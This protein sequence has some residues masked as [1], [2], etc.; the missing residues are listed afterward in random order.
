MTNNQGNNL[1][2]ATV[3]LVVIKKEIIN[4]PDFF[5]AKAGDPA[6]AD[7]IIEKVWSDKKTDQLRDYLTNNSIFLTMPSTTRTNILPVQLA[8][9]LSRETKVPW[10]YGDEIFNAEHTTAS[11]N[12]SR[13]KRIF[14]SREFTIADKESVE[15]LQEFS[16][17]IVDDIITSGG[18]IR[19]FAEF[20][21]N[22]N[23]SISHVIGLMGDRRFKIDQKTEKKLEKL[24]AEKIPFIKY[25]SIKYIT[26]TEAGGLIR[27]LNS[28]RSDNAI[29]KLTENLR[30]I[31]RT[32]TVRSSQRVTGAD[33][34]NCPQRK[35]KSNVKT[36]ERVS[37]Y[38]SAS[39]SKG[40]EWKIRFFRAGQE[41]KKEKVILSARL[42]KKE[43]QILLQDFS[44]RIAA[45]NDLGPVQV[46]FTQTGKITEIEPQKEKKLHRER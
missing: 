39:N 2:L 43:G 20:L 30:G 24:M 32:G 18:S 1:G 3:G 16:V 6:A 38:T 46:K 40:I 37:T 44:R 9:L 33:R 34:N 23:I 36:G 10:A 29:S 27:L 13:D 17:V 35:N 8:Q 22:Q 12:I 7:K 25:E 41:V 11:K 4:S 45:E 42:G 21:R 14:F 26:R 5:A 31:Q 28:A 15:I 19:G